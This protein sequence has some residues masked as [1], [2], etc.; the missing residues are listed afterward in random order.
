MD[1]RVSIDSLAYQSDNVYADLRNEVLIVRSLMHDH[2]VLYYD[3]IDN[4][5]VYGYT[6]EYCKGGSLHH[7]IHSIGPLCE[8]ELKILMRQMLSVLEYLASRYIV[9]RDIKTANI[10]IVEEHYYKLCDFGSS[11]QL[12]V[13][14]D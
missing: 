2:I 12:D 10:L 9:H 6:M 3:E 5:G 14:N 1:S 13:I 11:V 4:T 8:D 7:Y